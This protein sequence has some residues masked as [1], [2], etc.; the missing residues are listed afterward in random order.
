MAA[1]VVAAAVRRNAPTHHLTPGEDQ[2]SRGHPPQE[3]LRPSSDDG[4]NKPHSIAAHVHT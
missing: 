3:P 2:K 4:K 1:A